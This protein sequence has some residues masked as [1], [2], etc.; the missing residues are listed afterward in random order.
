MLVLVCHFGGSS[1]KRRS[2]T[3]QFFRMD[4][5]L[6]SQSVN[7]PGRL[8][9][10]FDLVPLEAHSVF[11]TPYTFWYRD[12]GTFR[13]EHLLAPWCQG[14]SCLCPRRLWCKMFFSNGM[15]FVLK[16][17]GLNCEP[18]EK[19]PGSTEACHTQSKAKQSKDS[20]L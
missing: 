8:W 1:P 14:A 2:H 18:F 10:A 13:L 5:R 6:Q 16:G 20:F 11:G 4:P 17:P 15:L 3:R 7:C 9:D 19:P 12:L